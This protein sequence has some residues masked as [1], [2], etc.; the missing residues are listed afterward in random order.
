QDKERE[1]YQILPKEIAKYR[2]KLLRITQASLEYEG[3]LSAASFQQ[4]QQVLTDA[5]IKGTV[6]T[7]NGL[8]E[9]VIVGQIIPAGT[10]FDVFLGIQYEETPRLAQEKKEKLA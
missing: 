8:K 10:G 6:D 5:A 1:T 2:R 9:N 3:W 4:T 7:L